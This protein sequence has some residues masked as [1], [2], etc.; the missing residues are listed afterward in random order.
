MRYFTSFLFVLSLLFVS[1]EGDPGPQG[2][3]GNV[4]VGQ[5]FERTVD[6]GPQNGYQVTVEIPT[7]IELLE[8]DMVLVYRF[9]GQVDGFDVWRILPETVYIETGE[10]FMYN[11]E[12]NFDLVTLYIDAPVTFNFNNLL[13]EERLGQIF[14]IVVLPVDFINSNDIDITDFNEVKA[15]L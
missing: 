5:S 13:P 10:E 12:H 11:F 8:S 6:F 2:P 14:R 4:I 7:N 3:P 15:F 1:C 9:V